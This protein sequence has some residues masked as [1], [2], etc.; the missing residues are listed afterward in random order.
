ML[1]PGYTAID[2]LQFVVPV[3]APEPSIVFCQVTFAT[4][5]LSEAAPVTVMV[6]WFV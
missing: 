1:V 2:A 4:P 3:A 6:D 5:T